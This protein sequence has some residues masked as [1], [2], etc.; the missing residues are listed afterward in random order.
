MKGITSFLVVLLA[1][2]GFTPALQADDYSLVDVG[3]IDDDQ[4]RGRHINNHGQAVGIAYQTLSSYHVVFWDGTTLSDITP[5]GKDWSSASYISDAGLILGS[6]GTS[7]S[8]D[9]HVYD[10]TDPNPV[11]TELPQIYA[12][13]T[14]GS[15]DGI[16]SSGVIV[17]YTD[18]SSAHNRSWAAKWTYS[19]PPG[20]A[21]PLSQHASDNYSRA[22]G[23]NDNNHIVGWSGDSMGNSRTAVWWDAAGAPHSLPGLASSTDD[24]ANRINNQRQICGFGRIDNKYRACLWNWDDNSND[25]VVTDVSGGQE[26]I[27]YDINEQGV[28][29]GSVGDSWDNET[30]AFIWD[31]QNGF[32]DLNDLVDAGA[33]TLVSADGINDHGHIVGMMENGTG[34]KRMYILIPEPITLTLLVTA[35]LALL[36]HRRSLHQKNHLV[37]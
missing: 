24:V 1:L 15:A 28:V 22:H 33:W 23:I 6:I 18:N 29:V 8:Y 36:R 4:C 14:A 7:S 5:D 34:D 19:V 25:Y 16:N 10:T 31:A 3:T 13:S 37:R 30:M 27:A 2:A 21:T 11:W 35:G 32:R 17:G 9:P 12:S 20:P 26:A